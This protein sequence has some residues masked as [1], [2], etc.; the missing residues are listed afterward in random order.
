[1][2]SLDKSKI[3]SY[4][5]TLKTTLSYP[6]QSFSEEEEQ[7]FTITVSDPCETAT[8]QDI[9]FTPAELTVT[10]GLTASVT[11]PDATDD[12]EDAKKVYSLCGDRSYAIY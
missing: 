1:M 2:V 10:N 6:A 9:V 4:V 11:F 5:V 7:E 8:M 3:N 12:V